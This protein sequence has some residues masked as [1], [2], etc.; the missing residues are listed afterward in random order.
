MTLANRTPGQGANNSIVVQ[1]LP[2]PIYMEVLI[3][4][5]GLFSFRS[6][7]SIN[8]EL[9]VL[10]KIWMTCLFCTIVI[11]AITTTI[12]FIP[13]IQIFLQFGNCAARITQSNCWRTD[14]GWI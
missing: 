2:I 9:K 1:F 4:F 3:I 8:G 7:I 5:D 10:A 6:E 13:L 12:P 14:A 11:L